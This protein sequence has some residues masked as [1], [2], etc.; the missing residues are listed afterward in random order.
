[1]TQVSDLNGAAMEAARSRQQ[2]LTKPPGA[3]GVLEELSAQLAGITGL[4]RPPLS[5]RTVIVCAGD[6]GVTAEGVSAFPAEVTVQM[7]QNFLD[8]GAAINVLAR[9]LNARVVVLD[10]GVAADLPAHPH[11]YAMKVRRGT[12]NLAREPAMQRR[13]A[14][15]AVEAGI[16][17][18]NAELAAGACVLLTG[19]M[20]I[21]NTTPTAAITAVLTG[22]PVSQVVGMG[23]GIGLPGWR[24]KCEAIERALAL[25]LPDVN[26]PIDILSKVGGLEIGAIAGI[27]LAGAAARVPVLIDGSIATAGAALAVKLCPDAKAFI[28]PS[29]RSAEP[30]HSVL[31]NYLELTPLLDLHLHLG[32]GSGALLALPLLEAAV[33]TLNEMATFDEA[34]VAQKTGGQA[35]QATGE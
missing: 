19:D 16:T 10:V 27:V 15:E 4:L 6:H 20:G 7:V 29:H 17:T 30:G 9:Q 32:E 35:T 11:L 24:R 5:P 18:A 13:E 34:K 26:D 33:A 8:G 28:I 14:V 21:G 25:H 1:M 23:T 12:A 31:L 3:L 2:Q 22:A